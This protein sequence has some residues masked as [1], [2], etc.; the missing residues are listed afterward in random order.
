MIT[1]YSFRL[2]NSRAAESKSLGEVGWFT[3]LIILQGTRKQIPPNGKRTIVL[4]SAWGLGE[5]LVPRR[6][7]NKKSMLAHLEESGPGNCEVLD[8]SLYDT[9]PNFVH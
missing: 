5:M 4:K 8:V 6:V 7:T 1:P 3:F 2:L 9:N